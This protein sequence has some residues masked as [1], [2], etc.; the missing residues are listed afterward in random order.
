MIPTELETHLLKKDASCSHYGKILWK[1]V[2]LEAR[3]HYGFPSCAFINSSNVPTTLEWLVL[4][5]IG[6]FASFILIFSLYLVLFSTTFSN[7][8]FG[9][10]TSRTTDRVPTAFYLFGLL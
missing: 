4:G 10:V 7:N 5:C 1:L 6:V 8:L 3:D 9:G 2:S